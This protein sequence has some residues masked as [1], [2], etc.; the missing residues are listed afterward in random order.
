MVVNRNPWRFG[1]LR[2]FSF[3]MMMKCL[4]EDDLGCLE[5][6][7]KTCSRWGFLVEKTWKGLDGPLLRPEINCEMSIVMNCSG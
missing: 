5:G 1:H 3:E 2:N 4:S 7:N 6:Q